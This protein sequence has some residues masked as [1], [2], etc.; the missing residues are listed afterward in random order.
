MYWLQIGIVGLPNVGKSTTFN[1]LTKLAIPAENFPFCTIEPNNVRHHSAKTLARIPM[2]KTMFAVLHHLQL[3]V[4]GCRCQRHQIAATGVCKPKLQSSRSAVRVVGNR[5]LCC[6]TLTS[7]D[8]C[9]A[10]SR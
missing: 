6:N 8:A 1:L 7:S 9:T 10:C 3:S 2:F 5:A 4:P